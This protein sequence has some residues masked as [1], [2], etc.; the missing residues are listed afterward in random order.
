[1]QYA[2]PV[3]EVTKVAVQIAQGD[4]LARTTDG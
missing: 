1:M 4:Y 3:D 2:R